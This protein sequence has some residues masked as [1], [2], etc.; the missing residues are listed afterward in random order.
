MNAFAA[1]T[2]TNGASHTNAMCPSIP[3]SSVSRPDRTSLD[4]LDMGD[5]EVALE[6]L[7][8]RSS[9][10]P[11]SLGPGRPGGERAGGHGHDL[12][13]AERVD[14]HEGVLLGIERGVERTPVDPGCLGD[15]GNLAR[16]FRSG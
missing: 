3:A 2:P 9:C 16:A 13:E 15:V 7:R 11:A 10:L 6:E 1:S 14:G 8:E 5:R 4:E 12:L